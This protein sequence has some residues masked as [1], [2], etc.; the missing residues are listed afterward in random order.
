MRAIKLT[1]KFIE[2]IEKAREELLS[3]GAII[4]DYEIVTSPIYILDD[5]TKIKEYKSICG[6]DIKYMDLPEGVDFIIKEKLK[7]NP[8]DIIEVQPPR[9]N[10]KPKEF[11][12]GKVIY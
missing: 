6:F 4:E 7:G 9:L 8:E 5:M 12:S 3:R 11:I 2:R 1:D 10:A